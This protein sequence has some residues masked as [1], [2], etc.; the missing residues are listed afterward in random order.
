MIKFKKADQYNLDHQQLRKGE[1]RETGQ[2]QQEVKSRDAYMFT[3][4]QIPTEDNVAYGLATP[5]ISTEDNH[6][7][8]IEESNDCEYDYI[9]NY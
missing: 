1:Q 5:Q 4:Q 2:Q 3:T 9:S 6:Y 8:Q 7:H